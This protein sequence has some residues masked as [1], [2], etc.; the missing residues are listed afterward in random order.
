MQYDRL[1]NW[2]Q[3]RLP[4]VG[5]K[6]RSLEIVT[7]PSGLACAVSVPK[8]R[9]DNGKALM[10]GYVRVDLA[11]PLGGRTTFY[12]NEHNVRALQLS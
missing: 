6:G 3:V 11:A 9:H 2:F 12:T 4:L 5:V 1:T 10:P 7:V 8:V